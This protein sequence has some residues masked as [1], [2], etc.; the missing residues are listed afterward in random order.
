MTRP[1][2]HGPGRGLAPVPIAVILPP[3]EPTPAASRRGGRH[4]HGDGLTAATAG[5]I[6]AHYTRHDDLVIDLSADPAITA[7]AFELDRRISHRLT[8]RERRVR[9]A[10]DQS[11]TPAPVRRAALVLDQAPGGLHRIDGLHR[12]TQWIRHRWAVLDD[13][14][15]LLLRVDSPIVDGRFTDPAS[16]LVT[17]ARACGLIYH[18]HLIA[19]TEPL[20]EPNGD[21]AAPG[22]PPAQLIDGRHSRT[23][24]DLYA[25]LAG[26][27]DD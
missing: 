2:H 21:G 1:P 17:A 20:P 3:T 19:V 22:I 23:H 24:L 13:S 14:G 26:G 16:T 10:A 6:L 25:F 18:Q 7:A 12:L 9:P 27:I 11:P 4:R 15:V 8:L 5:L